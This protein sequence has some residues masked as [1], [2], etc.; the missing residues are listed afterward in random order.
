VDT[1]A[2]IDIGSNSIR[3]Q[4]AEVTPA[5]EIRVIV[6]DRQVT[7]LGESV[8]RTGRLSQAAIE[9]TCNVLASMAQKYRAANVVAVRAV[10]TSA[11]RDA[12][13]QDEFLRRASDVLGT[14]VEVISGLEEARLIFMGVQS[15]WPLRKGRLAIIDVGGGSAEIMVG[16]NGHLAEAYSKKIGAVRMKEVF[17]KSEP[18]T[19]LELAQLNEYIDQ[20]LESVMRRLRLKT[21]D[22]AV[23]TSGT[24]A[25]MMGAINGISRSKRDKVDRLRASRTQVRSF[26]DKISSR[27]LEGRRKITGIGPRRAEIIVPGTAVLLHI[28]RELQ[29][30]NLYYTSAGLRDGVIADL[31]RRGVGKKPARLEADRREVVMG[32]AKRYGVDTTHVRKVAQVATQLFESTTP[33]HQL[34]PQYG[35]LLEAAAYLYDIGHFVSD[36]RHHRHSAYLVANSDLPGFTERE[37]RI[38]SNLCRYHRKGMPAASHADY[39]ALDAEAKHAVLLLTPLLRLS[40]ALDQTNEQRV[41]GIDCN[42]QDGFVSLVLRSNSDVKLE[43]WAAE[44]VGDM[45]RVVYDR[46]LLVEKGRP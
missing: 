23:A 44:Q 33:L 36:T 25:A 43:K 34:S 30:P 11:L 14:N 37:R 27:D 1:Y 12:G 41:R 15:R 35:G 4:A 5:G 18:P 7:R 9:F 40:A 17:L 20:R 26:Y 8:F 31:V 32:M 22:R 42:V 10:G 46:Q 13:N 28:M 16:E 38:L 24:A 29:L 6:S 39:Q 21:Y 2:A 45:F 3:M 19:N